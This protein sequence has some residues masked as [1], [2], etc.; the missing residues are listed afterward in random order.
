MG[1]QEHSEARI[2]AVYG[3]KGQL[4]GRY[5]GYEPTLAFRQV[6]SNIIGRPFVYPGQGRCVEAKVDV[7]T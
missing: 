5:Q 3:M 2:S 7:D 6:Q 4:S 1:E